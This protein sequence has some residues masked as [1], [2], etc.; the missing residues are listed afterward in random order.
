MYMISLDIKVRDPD[1]DFPIAQG[2][3]MHTSITRLAPEEMV[4]EVLFNIFGSSQR[5]DD[6]M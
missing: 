4:K 6:S 3:S 1:S 5:S 2:N